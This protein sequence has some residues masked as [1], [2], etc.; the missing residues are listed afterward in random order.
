MEPDE[1]D[2]IIDTGMACEYGCVNVKA[3]GGRDSG[4]GGDGVTAGS[5]GGVDSCRI[6]VITI[7]ND[8]D[9]KDLV[10]VND[11]NDN[12]ATGW[13]YSCWCC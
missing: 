10:D 5:A 3:D 7:V 11:E 1:F 8:D 6:A 12:E 4:G 9:G 13:V 2:N